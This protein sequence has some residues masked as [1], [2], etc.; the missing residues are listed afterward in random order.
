MND[1]EEG[2][3]ALKKAAGLLPK[4][5]TTEAKTPKGS[6]LTGQNKIN[7]DNVVEANKGHYREPGHGSAQ[8]IGMDVEP[9]YDNTRSPMQGMI[10]QENAIMED[11]IRKCKA[12]GHW[13]WKTGGAIHNGYWE[14]TR[15]NGYVVST[16]PKKTYSI[17]ELTSKIDELNSKI[18]ELESRRA[19]E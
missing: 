15:E 11:Q 17:E 14:G 7:Y 18:A 4:T 19:K 1:Y 6:T 2:V 10:D 5:M 3:Q 13:N 8:F 16:L 9:G 12:S